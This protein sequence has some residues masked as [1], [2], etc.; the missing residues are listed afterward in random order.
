[1]TPDVWE[2]EFNRYGQVV[3]P[4]R[5][6]SQIWRLAVFAFFGGMQVFQLVIEVTDSSTWTWTWHWNSWVISNLAGIALFVSSATVVLVLMIRRTPM[7]TIGRSGVQKGRRSIAWSQI[8]GVERRPNG[9]VLL[10]TDG[11]KLWI[12]STHT[13]NP[14]ALAWWLWS[15]LERS[16]VR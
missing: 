5:P 4:L 3:L 16:R 6:R 13:D 9:R 14:D 7:V 12:D 1:M 11:R 15:V 10:L 8:R 2:A